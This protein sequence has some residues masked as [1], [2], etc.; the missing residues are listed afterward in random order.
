M[1]SAAFALFVNSA[2][3]SKTNQHSFY[4]NSVATIFPRG[5]K[6]SPFKLVRGQVREAVPVVVRRNMQN[7]KKRSAQ[8]L[9][10]AETTVVCD[11][12]QLVARLLQSA[13]GCLN[14]QVLHE[15]SWGCACVLEEHARKVTRTHA[16]PGGKLFY[17]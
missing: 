1:D 8:S 17:R 7:T 2:P 12:F 11:L 6:P 10:R 5:T 9:N 14:S 3:W 15:P 16:G 4:C 13:P